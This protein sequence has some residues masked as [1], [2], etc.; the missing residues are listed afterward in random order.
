MYDPRASKSFYGPEFP[1]PPSIPMDRQYLLRLRETDPQK[2]A[3]WYAQYQ[4]YMASQYASSAA[5]QSHP[6]DRSS[7]HSGRS[8]AN[9]GQLK[10][11]MR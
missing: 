4:M 2:Y 5:E 7:V 11:S 10:S 3:Q 9:N 6:T 8:S 1:A